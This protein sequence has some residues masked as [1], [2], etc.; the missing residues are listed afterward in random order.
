[1]ISP[2]PVTLEGRGVRLEPLRREHAAALGAAANDGELWKLWYVA[3]SG[4]A[5]GREDAYVE[6][7][8]DAQAAGHA[9]PWVVRE[10]TTG[11]IVGSTRYHDIV[12]AID[13]VEIGYTFYAATWQRTHVNTATKLLLLEH[14]F[15]QLGC[16]VV[17]FRVD[18]LNLTSQQAVEALGA[19]KDGAL[20]HFMARP[21]GSPR[22][23][24][25]YSILAGEW[26]EVRARLEARLAKHA[27]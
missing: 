26:P 4:L 17:G 3:V 13:R 5:P 14:A 18:G 15:D 12:P 24:H 20:R 23:L 11:A 16:K 6:A 22:D 1:M 9:L 21:D 25:V 19:K 27:R 2:L 8:L 7:A 10:L